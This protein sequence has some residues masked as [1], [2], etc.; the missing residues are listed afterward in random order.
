MLENWA[1]V[2]S[3]SSWAHF[4]FSMVQEW[5]NT[6]IVSWICLCAVALEALTSAVVHVL[7]I[8]WNL[9]LDKALSEQ[10]VA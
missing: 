7:W 3:F 9:R 4:T 2:Q 10:E 8:F 6:Q 5:L 1:T